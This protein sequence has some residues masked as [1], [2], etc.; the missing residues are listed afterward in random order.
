MIATF[1]SGKFLWDKVLLVH[2]GF[3][4]GPNHLVEPT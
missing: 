4:L 3:V 1:S 2:I